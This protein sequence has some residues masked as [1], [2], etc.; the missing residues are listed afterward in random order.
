MFD[1]FD[2]RD[3]GEEARERWSHTEAYRES[4]RR[5]AGY[6]EREWRQIRAE[7]EEIVQSF[8]QL[9]ADGE[10]ANGAVARAVA[11]RHLQQICRWFYPCP[12]EMHRGLGELYVADERFARSYEEVAPGLA[13]Y[14]R[15]AIV[16]NA[17]VRAV[18]Q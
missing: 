6:R 5:A 4:T 17:E 1:G 15:Q 9:L 8:A 12:L 3:Y 16:A 14:V 7:S 18:N 11:E 2:H 13:A 10:P